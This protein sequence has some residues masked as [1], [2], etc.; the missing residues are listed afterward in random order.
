MIRGL[1]PH[2][3]SAARWDAGER[4]VNVALCVTYT[5]LAA[6]GVATADLESFPTQLRDGMSARAHVLDDVGSSAPQRWDPPFGTGK[7]HLMVLITAGSEQ[8]WRRTLA[9]ATSAIEWDG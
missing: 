1:L 9:K 5:G 8:S 6:L 3:R 2:V 7:I 4:D